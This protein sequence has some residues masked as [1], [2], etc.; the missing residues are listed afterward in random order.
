MKWSPMKVLGLKRHAIEKEGDL[1]LEN[2][3]SPRSLALSLL[4]V[5]YAL[6]QAHINWSKWITKIK[7]VKTKTWM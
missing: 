6:L 4:Q 5:T 7:Y 3:R 2:T 1:D